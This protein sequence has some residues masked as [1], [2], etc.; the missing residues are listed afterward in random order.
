MTHAFEVVGVDEAGYTV[1]HE[2]SSSGL[3]ISWA[4]R[5]IENGNAGNWPHIEVYDLRGAEA[6]RVWFWEAQ[7]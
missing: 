6:E 3:A 2:T 7:E 4:R 5:Y 1:L